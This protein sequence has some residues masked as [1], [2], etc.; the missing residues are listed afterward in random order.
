MF[1]WCDGTYLEDQDFVRLSG[2]A[3]SCYLYT[4]NPKYIEDIR[5]TPDDLDA[6]YKDGTVRSL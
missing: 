6:Q 4:R 2:V 1:R 5:I 3:R